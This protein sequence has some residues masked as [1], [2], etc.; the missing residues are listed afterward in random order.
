M[1]EFQ[2]KWIA[3]VLSDRIR[4][5]SQEEMMENVS[6]FYLSLEASDTPKHY[7]HNLADSQVNLVKSLMFG[8]KLM[9]IVFIN[10]VN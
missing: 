7:T 6:A 5:P 4:L 8:G 2:S 9:P 3:G 1:F 10:T